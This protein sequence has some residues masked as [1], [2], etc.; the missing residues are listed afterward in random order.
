[1]LIKQKFYTKYF[2]EDFRIKIHVQHVPEVKHANNVFFVSKQQHGRRWVLV[3][4][5]Q[6]RCTKVAIGTLGNYML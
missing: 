6:F 3:V 1:M 2:F 5:L 4:K